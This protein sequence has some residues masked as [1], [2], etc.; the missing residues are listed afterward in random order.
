MSDPCGSDAASCHRPVRAAGG[1]RVSRSRVALTHDVVRALRTAD[2]PVQLLWTVAAATHPGDPRLLASLAGGARLPGRRTDG[3]RAERY[4]RW[5]L[6]VRAVAAI[7]AVGLS[8]ARK[9]STEPGGGER[10][11]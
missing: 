2:V 3:R 11:R 4:P 9:G 5:W 6:G 8:A 7:A 1:G 10:D